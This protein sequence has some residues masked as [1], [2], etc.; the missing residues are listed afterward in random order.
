[1]V[2]INLKL[3][4][5]SLKCSVRRAVLWFLREGLEEKITKEMEIFMDKT[6]SPRYKLAN[7]KGINF[8]I[9]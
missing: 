6:K 8:S 1:M 5:G 9:F 2:V 7:V 3:V 4:S